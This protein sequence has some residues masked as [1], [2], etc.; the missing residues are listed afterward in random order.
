LT[1]LR[2]LENSATLEPTEM[3]LV[4]MNQWTGPEHRSKNLLLLGRW[5]ALASWADVRMFVAVSCHRVVTSANGDVTCDVN[6]LAR[7]H[8]RLLPDLAEIFTEG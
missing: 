8:K 7:L 1:C 3:M 4:M 2:N 6:L 5:I